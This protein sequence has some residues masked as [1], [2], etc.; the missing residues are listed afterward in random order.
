MV[1][2]QVSPERAHVLG[3][4]SQLVVLFWEVLE[5]LEGGAQLEETSHWMMCPGVTVCPIVCVYF[6]SAMR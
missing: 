1:W 3:T 5:T 2:K 4:W 6:L